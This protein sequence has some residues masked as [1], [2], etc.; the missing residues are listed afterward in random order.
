VSKFWIAEH[1]SHRRSSDFAT[2][3]LG[4]CFIDR[5]EVGDGR[6][7]RYASLNYHICSIHNEGVFVLWPSH[8]QHC[9][10]LYTYPVYSDRET[11]WWEDDP[12]ELGGHTG[13][14]P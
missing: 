12:E 8:Q 3:Q 14:T 2:Y 6:F 4:P 13:L 9:G 10:E 1:P 5:D 7:G 11:E